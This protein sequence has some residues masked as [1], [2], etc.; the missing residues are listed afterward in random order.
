MKPHV[1]TEFARRKS[2]G[3]I[4][5]GCTECDNH[6]RI[7]RTVGTWPEKVPLPTREELEK[8]GILVDCD[9]EKVRQVM[10]S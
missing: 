7:N 2:E 5:F 1:W 10:K 8:A 9:E 3:K 4:T 6:L